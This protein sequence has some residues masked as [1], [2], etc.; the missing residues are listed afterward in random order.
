MFLFFVSE[1]TIVDFFVWF[2]KVVS[3]FSHMLLCFLFSPIPGF[4]RCGLSAHHLP[5]LRL[6][7]HGGESGRGFQADQWKDP[8]RAIP[9]LWRLGEI[10]TGRNGGNL[11]TG[12]GRKALRERNMVGRSQNFVEICRFWKHRWMLESHVPGD[13]WGYFSC[14]LKGAI[15]EFADS[16]FGH[17]FAKGPNREAA[18]KSLRFALMNLETWDEF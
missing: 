11:S 5:L 16:Q 13:C 7:Y 8:Q 9:I 1:L 3:L 6:S 10:S 12:S 15:H 4:L 2:Q 18:R 17:I 14:G